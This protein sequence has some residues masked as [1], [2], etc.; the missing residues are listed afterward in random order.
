MTDTPV[1]GLPL[2]APAQAQ[3]HVTVN[4]A[5]SRIDGLTQIVLAA[6]DVT[7]PPV[8]A[9]EGDI[10][11]VPPGAVNAWT[12]QAGKL[13]LSQ[14]G[15]W[16]FVAPR[17]GWRAVVLDAGAPAIFDGM[18][19]R[20]GAVT[21]DESGAGLSMRSVSVDVSVEAGGSVTTPV[22]F[23]ERSL[24]FGVTGRVV[25]ALTGTATAWDLGVTGD[26]GRYG[27]GLGMA[28]NS[29]VNGPS[30][31][32]VYWSPTALELTAQ[33]GDFAGGTVRL[34]AHFAELQLPDA[35]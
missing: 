19:W 27:T 6:V 4:E 28:Q 31:P 24:A 29:W 17:R 15:G 32:L 5:L 1:L 10:Y 7:T 18:A 3:K 2:V 22:I 30:M 33:G 25:S 35:I 34:V 11:A 26:P 12:G 13:A 20:V 9:P 14:N 23:P 16:V 21:L 8:A